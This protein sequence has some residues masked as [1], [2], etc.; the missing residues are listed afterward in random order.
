MSNLSPNRL[1][2]CA[3]KRCG[4]LR[5]WNMT[6]ADMLLHCEIQLLIV[7]YLILMLYSPIS[8]ESAG[9]LNEIVKP[10]QS[11]STPIAPVFEVKKPCQA[12]TPWKAS[13]IITNKLGPTAARTALYAS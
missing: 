7:E 5:D 10:T 1:V 13:P 2:W 9:Q 4:D 6:H 3:G 8:V 11:M 12:C